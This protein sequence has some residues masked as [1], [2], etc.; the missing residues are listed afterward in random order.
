MKL[1]DIAA[2]SIKSLKHRQM[3]AWLTILGIVIGI[4]A[5]ISLLTLGESFSEQVNK[6]LGALGSNTI[7]VI[8]SAGGIGAA[9]SGGGMAP[10]SGKLFDKD[11]DRVKRVPEVDVVARLLRGRTTIGFKDKNITASI[12]GIEPGVFEKTT[13]IKMAN[14]RFLQE[15]DRRVVVIG[16]TIAYDTFGSRNIVSVNSYMMINGIKYR[17]VGIMEKNG[18]GFG[19]GNNVDIGIYVPFEEAR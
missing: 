17:V 10:T 16:D 7:F 3:R 5:V 11:V 15:N 2:Y 19:A 1:I 12:S 9:F 13:A 4:A 18:G 14:G 6:Q 8:P